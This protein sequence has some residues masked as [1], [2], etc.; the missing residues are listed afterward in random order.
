MKEK[1]KKLH[2]YKKK[3]NKETN[4]STQA[5]THDTHI[6]TR[7]NINTRNTYDDKEGARALG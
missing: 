1:K 7:E 5:G 2:A 6:H 4:T 3:K